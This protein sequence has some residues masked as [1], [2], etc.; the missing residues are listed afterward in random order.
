VQQQ[1]TTVRIQVPKNLLAA[2]LLWFFLGIFG[3]H[4]F[5]LGRTGSAVG[6]SRVLCK[7]PA[8]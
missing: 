8:G 4:R 2:Y 5:Y 6:V 7:L 3:A 1:S